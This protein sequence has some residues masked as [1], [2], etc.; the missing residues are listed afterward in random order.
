MLMVL[1]QINPMKTLFLFWRNDRY[2]HKTVFENLNR[3]D[4]SVEMHPPAQQTDTQFRDAVAL[5][6]RATGDRVTV[7]AG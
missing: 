6:R 1:C 3:R 2:L 7:M 4:V 5:L